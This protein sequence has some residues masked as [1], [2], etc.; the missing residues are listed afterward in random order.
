MPV[1]I[2]L[3]DDHILVRQ[4]LKSLLEREGFRVLAEASDG[5]E[6][7]Q[8]VESFRPDIVIIDI[9]MPIMNGL[10]AAREIARTSPKTQII[11]LTQH[12][13]SSTY[14]RPWKRE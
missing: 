12:D 4:S 14:P 7:L 2:V 5:Q 6:A 3:A 13:E 1:R 10:S 9:T 8:N 11:L